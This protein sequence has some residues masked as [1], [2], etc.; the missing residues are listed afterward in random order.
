MAAA[1]GERHHRRLHHRL[2]RRP[3]LR[4]LQLQHPGQRLH[5]GAR[6]LHQVLRVEELT[7]AADP[8]ARWAVGHHRFPLARCPCS[9]SRRWTTETPGSWLGAGTKYQPPA[10]LPVPTPEQMAYLDMGFTQFMHFS[11]TCGW[12]GPAP[13]GRTARPRLT[14]CGAAG[15]LET[16]ST[17]AST[18]SVCPPPCSTRRRWAQTPTTSP[19][20]INGGSG[21]GRRGAKALGDGS[22]VP[23][24]GGGGEEGTP[25]WHVHGT[26]N[27]GAV[28][29]RHG[30]RDGRR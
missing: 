28:Q 20:R 30:C 14:A 11:V 15:P 23:G 12:A 17:T 25:L 5:T 21:V 8:V 19:Q 29:G 1:A 9:R 4:R 27:A 3:H 22:P 7:A 16:L 24:K 10:G 18:A 6:R 26:E 2:L 13:P